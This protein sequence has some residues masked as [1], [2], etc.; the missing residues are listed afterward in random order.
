M[1]QKSEKSM[2]TIHYVDKA[3]ALHLAL[4]RLNDLNLDVMDVD[5]N[6][7]QI[8]I[9][10]PELTKIATDFKEIKSYGNI[11][12]AKLRNVVI[13]WENPKAIKEVTYGGVQ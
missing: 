7:Q 10:R 11:T 12:K 8:L 5:Y 9:A 13:F 4:N 6:N 1:I 3:R 2:A